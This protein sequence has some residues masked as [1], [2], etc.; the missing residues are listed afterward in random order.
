MKQEAKTLPIRSKDSLTIPLHHLS[1]GKM[2]TFPKGPNREVQIDRKDS[3]GRKH[4]CA[5]H[6]SKCF[7]G[8]NTVAFS[9]KPVNCV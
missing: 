9:N 3:G 1:Q 5:G 2:K 4:Q 8:I 7:S 6:Y